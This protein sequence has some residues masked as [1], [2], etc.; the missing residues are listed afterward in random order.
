MNEKPPPKN[1]SEESSEPPSG[2][3]SDSRNSGSTSPF[4]FWNL[5]GAGAGVSRG[6]LISYLCSDLY[7]RRPSDIDLA[8]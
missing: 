8:D 2:E 5:H 7:C 3:F 1:D 6:C 4:L